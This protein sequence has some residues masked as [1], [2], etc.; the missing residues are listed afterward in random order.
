MLLN[1][2]GNA[3]RLGW[4]VLEKLNAKDAKGLI[5]W[6]SMSE[7]NSIKNYLWLYFGFV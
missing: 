4:L 1:V 2:G 6:R 3:G 5:A 7:E